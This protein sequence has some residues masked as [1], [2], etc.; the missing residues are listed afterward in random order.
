MS[1]YYI[2]KAPNGGD[3]EIPANFGKIDP[4]VT[5]S[6]ML[7]QLRSWS[8]KDLT[9]P[10]KIERDKLANDL[11]INLQKLTPNDISN[12]IIKNI[13]ITN[14]D[15]IDKIIP[16][17]NTLIES[18]GSYTNIND[19][20]NKYRL[21]KKGNIEKLFEQLNKPLKPK[22]FKGLSMDGIL[23]ATNLKQ[24]QNRIRGKIQENIEF[25]LSSTI[26]ASVDT[27]MNSVLNG[28]N[29][30]YKQLF[31]SNVLLG[32]SHNYNGRA[33]NIDGFTFFNNN[34]DLSL[35]LGVFKRV[36]SD[37]QKEELYPILTEFNKAIQFRKYGKIDLVSEEEFDSTSF[38]NG[39]LD[40]KGKL[41]PSVFDQILDLSKADV[42]RPYITRILKAVADHI[43][44]NN[45]AL[46]KSI[47]TLFWTLNPEKYGA[48]ALRRE[49]LQE[50]FTNNEV[51]LDQQ[52]KNR[53]RATSL[54]QMK[55]KEDFFSANEEIITDLFQQASNK[56]T[57]NQDLV[58]FGTDEKSPFGI[59]TG[60]FPRTNGV[61]IYGVRQN[62][63]GEPEVLKQLFTQGKEKIIYKNR[64][65]SKDTYDQTELVTPNKSGLVVA[66]K[67]TFPQE[68]I[69]RIINKGDRVNGDLLVVGVHAGALLVKSNKN[70][71][72]YLGFNKVKLMISAQA[73]EDMEMVKRTNPSKYIPITDGNVL[74]NGDLF[75]DPGTDFYKQ[76][77][78]S[79]EENVYSW[80]QQ[81]GK[82]AVIKAT[83]RVEI[84]KG[85][86]YSFG[87][88]TGEELRNISIELTQVGRSNATMSTFNNTSVA[89]N[90]D[91]FVITDDKNIKIGKV[92]DNTSNKGIV[93]NPK[94]ARAEPI[95]YTNTDIQ[96]FT[97]RDISSNF[98]LTISRVNDWKITSLSEESAKE[99]PKYKEAQ[100]IIPSNVSIDS[101]VLLPSGYANIGKF[102]DMNAQIAPDERVVTNHILKLMQAS[103]QDI[104]GTKLYLETSDPE[105]KSGYYQRNLYALHRIN[106]FDSL[107]L[108]VKNELN[109]IQPGTYFSVYNDKNIDSNIYRIIGVN[110][111]VVTAHLNKFSKTG[112]IITVEKEFN[113]SDLLAQH[114]VG[115]PATIN[116]IAALYLQY[117]NDKF[118]TVIKAI[119]EKLNISEVRNEK[120]INTTIKKMKVAFKPIGVDVKA[121]SAIDGN[122]KDG[123][124]AK[125]ETTVVNGKP[126][127]TILLNKESGVSSDLVHETLHI[128]LTALR[129]ASPE[130]YN[131]FLNSVLGEE[132]VDLDV[133]AREELFVKKVSTGISTDTDF[134][135][136]NIQDFSV[137]LAAAIKTL[138]PDFDIDLTSMISDPLT[139]LNTPLKDI[140]GVSLDN[141]HPMFN[142]SAIM[143]EPAMREWMTANE[144]ILKC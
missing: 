92:T 62:Q 90:D 60:I 46:F 109:V 43:Q 134:L 100:Y 91:Y 32:S 44:P 94:T 74:S 133:T 138:N 123:Q 108:D 126:K 113:V 13:V 71:L 22:Y 45:P 51:K 122:F 58:K 25:G 121:V 17:I 106:N 3:I 97:N 131:T 27:F 112:K 35:F 50:Q 140:F 118:S 53:L 75:I 10:Q 33:W 125:I 63:F 95:I 2:I 16:S 20:L 85:L 5:T 102:R 78:Y 116:S 96:F 110:N 15:N 54:E 42:A 120:E 82:D 89:K 61:L 4:D 8:G 28:R 129:Y 124:H 6:E 98:S 114:V 23:G 64:E 39:E 76:V 87:G 69:K 101:L 56:I 19:A 111:G 142:L 47:Q 68:L 115:Q 55:N 81:T 137:S 88:I 40:E 67:T 119:N 59:V 14:L 65:D 130:T 80:V 9:D 52:Y 24:E 36:G 107:G 26:P 128:Y 12:Q 132:G 7:S 135:K 72:T 143:T 49:L 30:Q 144:I 99:N 83:P 105:G 117:G 70:V 141:S 93:F 127:T 37:V 38:F 31:K 79:D 73:Q 1:C 34:D 86:V 41:I 84:K 11:V 77:L 29:K 139:I 66:T 21:K 136:D 103:G 18:L 57:I 104:A 48:D